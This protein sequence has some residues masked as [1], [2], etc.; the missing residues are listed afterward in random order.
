[1]F[2]Y[3]PNGQLEYQHATATNSREMKKERNSP[4]SLI[5]SQF[6]ELL[7]QERLYT[8]CGMSLRTKSDLFEPSCEFGKCYMFFISLCKKKKTCPFDGFCKGF[9]WY[10]SLLS[11]LLPENWLLAPVSNVVLSCLLAKKSSN[12]ILQN[13][14]LFLELVYFCIDAELPPPDYK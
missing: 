9:R 8:L 13:I 12:Q 5:K 14:K 1:M 6:C 10:C 2:C 11:T 3:T 7:S 4:D